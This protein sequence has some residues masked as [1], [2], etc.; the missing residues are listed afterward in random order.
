MALTL[1]MIVLLAAPAAQAGLN[2]SWWAQYTTTEGRS[3][4]FTL[5]LNVTGGTVSGTIA[6]ARGS[7][8]ITEGA[9]DGNDVTF[10]VT[11]RSSYDEI[12]VVF[13]GGLE[14]GV[15]RLDMYVGPRAPIAVTARRGVAPGTPP[16]GS[17]RGGRGG[18][19]GRAGP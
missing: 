17:G 9:A 6:S 2:G 19:G 4:E 18:R 7:V 12:D 8:P 11:R 14:G 15:L 13:K 10:T 1:L 5:T 3:H 16:P